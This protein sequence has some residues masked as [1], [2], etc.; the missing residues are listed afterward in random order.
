VHVAEGGNR[1]SLPSVRSSLMAQHFLKRA[2]GSGDLRIWIIQRGRECLLAPIEL[3]ESNIRYG[4]L[5]TFGMKPEDLEGAVLWVKQTEWKEFLR[6]VR[7]S[8]GRAS[9]A[10]AAAPNRQLDHQKIVEMASAMRGQRKDLSIGA[11]AAS[12]AYELPRNEKTGKR[13]DTRNIERIISHLWE[14]KGR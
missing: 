8:R 5:K 3:L 2:I 12:I 6:E 11:A 13:R 9:G 1:I 14:A 4:I 7:R 10:N